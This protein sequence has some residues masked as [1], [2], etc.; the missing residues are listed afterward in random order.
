MH[1]ELGEDR[2][3]AADPNWPRKSSIVISNKSW[4]ELA[5]SSTVS[6][7]LDGQMVR[8][9]I[10]QHFIIIIINNFISFYFLLIKLSLSQPKTSHTVTSFISLSRLTGVGIKQLCGT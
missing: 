7:G 9:C 5:T 1:N 2:T 10:V 6:R 3:R 8:N 4:G